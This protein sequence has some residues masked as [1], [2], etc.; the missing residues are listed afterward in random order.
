M[1]VVSLSVAVAIVAFWQARPGIRF[2]PQ[3]SKKLR[4]LFFEI[5]EPQYSIDWVRAVEV[6]GVVCMRVRAQ[7]RL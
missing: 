4:H 3:F 6:L 7:L 5:L 2:E 1:I